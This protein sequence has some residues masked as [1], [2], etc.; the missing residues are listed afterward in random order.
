M[1]FYGFEF[2]VVVPMALFYAVKY[3]HDIRVHSVNQESIYYR[4]AIIAGVLGTITFI[5][6]NVLYG[7]LKP[8]AY[9]HVIPNYLND[10]LTVP[11]FV[12]MTVFLACFVKNVYNAMSERPGRPENMAS[13]PR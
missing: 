8:R 3:Y 1:G 6:S 11:L 4:P 10:F 2:A 9:L 7:Y 12:L 13:C 5:N